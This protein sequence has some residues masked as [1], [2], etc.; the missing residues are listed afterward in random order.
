MQSKHASQQRSPWIHN[1]PTLSLKVQTNDVVVVCF[2]PLF[3]IN[4]HFF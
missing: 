4:I 2:A 3:C 1:K